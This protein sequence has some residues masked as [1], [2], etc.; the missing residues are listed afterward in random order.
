MLLCTFGCNRPEKN[1]DV[2]VNIDSYQRSSVPPWCKSCNGKGYIYT[3]RNEGQRSE[4]TII[5]G[6]RS[7]STTASRKEVCRLCKGTGKKYLF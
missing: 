4:R 7:Q 1:T 5:T 3:S 6:A 2:N